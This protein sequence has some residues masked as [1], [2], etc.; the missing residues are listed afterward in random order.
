[1]VA[2]GHRIAETRS[3][4]LHRGVA[5]RLRHDPGVLVAA[6]RRV[7][8]WLATGEGPRVWAERWAAVLGGSA[9]DVISILTDP[10]ERACDLRQVS[11]FAG[12]IDA[13]A[14][15]AIL[16]QCPQKDDRR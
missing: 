9:E 5:R 8:E 12:T 15:W 7:A 11:P 6:R 3:L 16:R 10:A 14:R 13:R 1:M 4:A 2:A